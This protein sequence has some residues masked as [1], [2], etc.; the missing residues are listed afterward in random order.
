VARSLER[1]LR[2]QLTVSV[3]FVW[4]GIVLSVYGSDAGGPIALLGMVWLVAC[5]HR[6]GR[7][8]A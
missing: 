6:L 8:G 3:L 2:T 5:V 7:L 4:L 1:M